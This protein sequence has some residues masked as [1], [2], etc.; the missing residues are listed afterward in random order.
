MAAPSPEIAQQ[1][2]GFMSNDEW[3][4]LLAD[5]N[6][7]VETMEALPEGETRQEV[8]ALLDSIDAVHREAL[9]RLV[10]LFKD[11]VLEKVVSD[12]AIHTLMELYDLLPQ[13][14]PPKAHQPAFATIPIRAVPA[15]PPSAAPRF[16]HWVPAPVEADQSRSGE[17]NGPLAIDG[18]MLLLARRDSNW[19]AVDAACPVD[20]ADLSGA[21]LSGFTLSCPA[22]TGC[23]YDIR[24]GKRIGGGPDLG[25]HPVKT[26]ERGRVLV[27][28]DMDFQPALP[29]F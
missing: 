27:G 9:R 20:G 25:C 15:T 16:P 23:H 19:F 10:R 4:A 6:R 7:R 2:I 22:H 17:I 18:E 24:A 14:K 8:F 29:S 13:D 12:P 11:G 1:L 28:L 26:D 5:L 21:S 3:A